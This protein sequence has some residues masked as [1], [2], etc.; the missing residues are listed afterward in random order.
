M[1]H[2]SGIYLIYLNADSKVDER[3]ATSFGFD[4]KYID[5]EATDFI[6]RCDATE[7][8]WALEAG[9]TYVFL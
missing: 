4:I 1:L 6:K 9:H 5:E 2:E 7:R 3:K 8:K